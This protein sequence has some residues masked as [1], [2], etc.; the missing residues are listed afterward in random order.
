MLIPL[1]SCKL[2]STQF[3]HVIY[4]TYHIHLHKYYTRL[5]MDGFC[6]NKVNFRL[7]REAQSSAK[8]IRVYCIT[9]LWITTGRRQQLSTLKRTYYPCENLTTTR[10]RKLISAKV[11]RL[12]REYYREIRRRP[13][14]ERDARL[15]TCLY[16]YERVI[17][18]KDATTRVAKIEQM[19]GLMAV[20]IQR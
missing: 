4:N 14:L 17:V 3:L 13:G 11:G 1:C 19:R 2:I 9:A 8:Y 7:S 18:Q 12:Y 15:W 20:I 16:T 6:K 10:Q 5:P